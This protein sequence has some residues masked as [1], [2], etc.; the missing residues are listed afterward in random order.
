M[1][2]E[3]GGQLA[4]WMAQ[5]RPDMPVLYMSGYTEDA[6]VRHGVRRD[7]GAFLEKPFT[8]EALLERVEAM[9]R[10]PR[11]NGN[12]EPVPRAA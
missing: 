10:A 3:S 7:G 6:L 1:P 9:I 11:S 12:S 8:E 2:G 4:E 5:V